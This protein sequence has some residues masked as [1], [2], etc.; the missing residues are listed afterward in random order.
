VPEAFAAL[1]PYGWDERVATL[2]ASVPAGDHVPGRVVRVER[3]A[4]SVQSPGGTR[5]ARGE[6]LP[7]V[8]DWVAL[9]LVDHERAAVEAVLSRWSVLS[10]QDPAREA[11]QVLAS[12]LDVVLVVAPSDRL[13]LARV[14]RELLIAWESGA[15]PVVVLTKADLLEPTDDMRATAERRLVG[16]EVILTSTRTGEGIDEVARVLQPNRTGALIG[17]SGAGKSS[18]ANALLGEDT[19]ATGDVRDHD[20]RGRHT[21]TSRQLVP[22]PGGGVL[23]DT[24][25]LRSLALWR[26]DDGL[27][28]A[29]A[30]VEELGLL[31][32]FDDCHHDRE[33]G[34]AVQAAVAA[35]TLDPDRFASYRK[36]L[37]EVA[38]AERSHD[39]RARR[40]EQQRWKA[41]T[42]AQRQARAAGRPR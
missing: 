6:L 28:A 39:E 5:L 38:Y 15:V 41:V 32:R 22:V 14:E 2:Y 34:C 25:G 23:I 31:C 36:L 24:P 20:R 33:P 26:G 19:L 3:G 16:A 9:R 21:T 12:N 8:G 4:C 27:S 1:A 37:A 17:P 18:L 29:F 40:A 13:H 10:R 42:K 30:D 11:E 7:A 35:G